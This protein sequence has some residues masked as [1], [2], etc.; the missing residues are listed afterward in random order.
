M[1]RM[2]RL[3]WPVSEAADGV[4]GRAWASPL[5]HAGTWLSVA[6]QETTV[7]MINAKRSSG[8]HLISARMRPNV[9]C[10]WSFGP[11][12]CFLL[13]RSRRATVSGSVSLS[14]G[15]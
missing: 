7:G 6:V 3:T 12:A 15:H 9:V 11:L 8:V 4:P 14:D 10:P 1:R 5:D 13:A 2:Y